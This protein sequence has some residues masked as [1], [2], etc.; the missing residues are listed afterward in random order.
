MA[1]E[2]MP[3][4]EKA[5]PGH[6][7]L[8][9]S[10]GLRRTS[11]PPPSPTATSCES[12]FGS[13][14]EPILHHTCAGR[15]SP[16]AWFRTDWQRGGALTGYATYTDESNI[17]RDVVVK[18]PVPP[19]ER[20]WL[21]RLQPHAGIVPRLFAHGESLNGYDLAWVVMERLP[22]GPLGQA[23]EGKE[24]DLLVEA[25]GRFYAAA[26]QFPVDR[27]AP[28]RDW[29]KLFEQ[30]RSHIIGTH[31]VAHEQRWKTA[32]KK[33]H[34]KLKE[35]L[36]IWNHRP[37]D[38]WCHGDLHLANA[39]TRVSPPAG[40][41]VLLDLAEV[42]PGYWVEDAVYFEHLFWARRHRLQGRKL[43][44]QI[45]HERKR[46]GF[47]VE[48]DWPRYASIRRALMAMSTPALLHFDGDPHH[49]QAALEVLEMEV[50]A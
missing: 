50:G 6:G 25:A 4:E 41:A 47:K 46:L 27:P 18:L 26:Q 22:H 42:H 12:P 3:G 45:A 7:R 29:E 2:G 1:V 24:F 43:V 11:T 48:A 15:L 8:A 10:P 33:A 40:P 30:A 19:G 23:W 16:I 14:L 21:E 31:D 28:A 34:R 13:S 5:Q 35:W 37:V 39:M 20:T 49:V 36:T 9:V 17:K 44:S 38:Q 32:I